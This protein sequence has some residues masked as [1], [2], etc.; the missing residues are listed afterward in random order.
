MCRCAAIVPPMHCRVSP[1]LRV[2]SHRETVTRH[3]Y[4]DQSFIPLQKPFF[5]CMR[6]IFSAYCKALCAHFLSWFTPHRG[7]SARDQ[8]FFS[9]LANY[10]HLGHP[11]LRER[12]IHDVAEK[13]WWV[14][15]RLLH[16]WRERGS[17][18]CSSNKLSVSGRRAAGCFPV[19]QPVIR[20]IFS[21]QATEEL[22]D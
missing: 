15:K 9:S 11:V 16:V 4:L 13:E 6:I 8:V 18:A 3:L 21:L 1:I 17:R 5:P 19:L 2:R 22:A 12:C 20:A 14:E 7:D 10:T